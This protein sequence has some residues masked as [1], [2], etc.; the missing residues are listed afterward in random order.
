[1]KKLGL[2]CA[3]ATIGFAGAASAVELDTST[4]LH[5][6]TVTFSGYAGAEA[7]TNFPALVRIPANSAIYA[8]SLD[9]RNIC[10]TDADGNLAPHEIDVWNPETHDLRIPCH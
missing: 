6:C 9:G 1:M 5:R 3:L 7:L 2:A 8:D 4:F 10:F